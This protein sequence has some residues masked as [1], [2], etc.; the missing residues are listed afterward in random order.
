MSIHL[1]GWH[2][3]GIVVS[4]LWL[5]SV[6]TYI[7]YELKSATPVQHHY[8]V[9]YVPGS[10]PDT[11][12]YIIDGKPASGIVWDDAQL[13]KVICLTVSLLPIVMIWSIGYAI[14]WIQAGFRKK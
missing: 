4:I 1:G 11:N 3:L 10:V 7:F 14:A 6:S 2:R 8:F 9:E 12:T 5:V 13:K